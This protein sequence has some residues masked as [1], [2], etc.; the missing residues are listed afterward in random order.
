MV[1][2]PTRIPLATYRLQFSSQLRFR[3]ARR[4]VRYLSELG[5]SDAYPSPL[6]R[7]REHSSH[8]Y[9]VI[10]PRTIDPEFGSEAD[11]QDFAEELQEYGLG[12]MMDIVPNHMGIDDW[13]NT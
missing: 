4:L 9:D 5:V 13:H 1:L 2:T 12:L 7:A 8:G 11:F 3:D 10:D 6:F